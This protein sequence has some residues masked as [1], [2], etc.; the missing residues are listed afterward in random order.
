VAQQPL[1]VAAEMIA[2]GL[3]HVDLPEG[4]RPRLAQER[5]GAAATNV[6]RRA[7]VDQRQPLIQVNQQ[8]PVDDLQAMLFHRASK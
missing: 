1:D 5:Q 2:H 7:R 6:L 8:V 4:W 3:Q